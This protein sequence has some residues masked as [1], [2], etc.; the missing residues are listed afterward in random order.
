MGVRPDPA[1]PKDEESDIPASVSLRVADNKREGPDMRVEYLKEMKKNLNGNGKA[2]RIV[3]PDT[4]QRAFVSRVDDDGLV[5]CA[6]LSGEHRYLGF[7]LTQ[8]ELDLWE[9]EAF[10]LPA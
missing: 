10:P 2:C 9:P 8:K 4:G 6:D 7:T 5:V 3:R 1:T